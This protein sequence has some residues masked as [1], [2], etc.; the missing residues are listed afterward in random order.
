MPNTPQPGRIPT[1]P[2]M[3][4]KTPVGSNSSDKNTETSSV[5]TSR[6]SVIPQ[7]TPSGATQLQPNPKKK[8]SMLGQVI[9]IGFALLVDFLEIILDLF[10]IGVAANRII[11]IVVAGIFF[12]FAAV[13]GLTLAEDKKVYGSIA[14][15]I[16]GEFIPGL[17]IAPFFAIDAWYITRSIKAKD[18]ALQQQ[19]DEINSAAIAEQERQDWI[20]NYEQQQEMEEEKDTV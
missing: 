14:G 5:P 8:M 16:V 4:G 12:L 17:D 6:T 13:K 18:R 10:V 7:R 1:P 2:Q 3:S 15:T 19:V 9:F 20:A 11:D